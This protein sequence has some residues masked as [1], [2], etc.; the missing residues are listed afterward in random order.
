MAIAL[1]AEEQ[2]LVSEE[3]AAYAASLASDEARARFEPL[4]DA[5][6]SGELPEHVLEPL[7]Q[8]LEL[9]LQSGRIRRVHR[10]LGEQTL[11]RLYAR[12]PAGAARAEAVA[13]LNHAL[14]QLEGHTI[15]SVRVH[16]RTPGTYLLMV[17]TDQCEMTLSFSPDGAG[18]EAVALG[19]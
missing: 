18:V 3:V 16:P 2:E 15:E 6:R 10:A 13:D 8:V 12:T 14:G 7:G 19:I 4:L 5:V 9:G 17:T 11:L 1:K